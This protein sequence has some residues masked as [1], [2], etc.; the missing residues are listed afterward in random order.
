MT[1]DNAILKELN[2]ASK[3][4][5]RID[6]MDMICNQKLSEGELDQE[7]GVFRF[8]G[9]KSEI[10]YDSSSNEY[11]VVYRE[12]DLIRS[13]RIRFDKKGKRKSTYYVDYQRTSEKGFQRARKRC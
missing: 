13:K 12:K 10:Y 8:A 2:T 4:F 5:D 7:N 1:V 6:V 3:A 9:I 11:L